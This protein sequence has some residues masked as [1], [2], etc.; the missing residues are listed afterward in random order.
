M[1]RAKG[2][3]IDLVRSIVS[4]KARSVANFKGDHLPRLAITI[5]VD[6]DKGASVY[7]CAIGTD[8]GKSCS[9]EEAHEAQVSN[10]EESNTRTHRLRQQRYID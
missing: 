4:L 3:V 6:D 2:S 5:A 1:S 7:Q 10:L 9:V 8:I